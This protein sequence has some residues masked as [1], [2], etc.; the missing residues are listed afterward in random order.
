MALSTESRDLFP[1]VDLDDACGWLPA[2]RARLRA[3]CPTAP[4]AVINK[5]INDACA[6]VV[7][8]R[9]TPAP[10]DRYRV[11]TFARDRLEAAL[12]QHQVERTGDTNP[13][14]TGCANRAVTAAP[15]GEPLQPGRAL[16]AI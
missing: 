1:V 6:A 8:G 14:T 13:G 11:S 4:E 10:T 3:D 15:P 7:R 12:R 9:R 2:L 16:V 5:C